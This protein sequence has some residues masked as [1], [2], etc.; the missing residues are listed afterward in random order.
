MNVRIS[1]HA[2]LTASLVASTLASSSRADLT[3]DA[4]KVCADAY[5]QAQTL[6]DA[7][8]L[9]EAR[10]QLRACAQAS[11]SAFIVTDCTEWLADLERLMPSVVLVARD[12]RGSSLS[13]VAVSADGTPLTGALDGGAIE[14][15]PGSHTF[16]FTAADGARA[17]VSYTVLE[18]QKAQAVAVT[19]SALPASAQP[20]LA[21]VEPR[22]LDRSVAS[23][24]S[25]WT[26]QRTLGVVTGGV[27][28]AGVAVGTV[29]GVLML[30]AANGQKTNCSST[31]SCSDY[32][33]ASTDHSTALKDG[34]AATAA[35]IAGGVLIAGGVIL[36]LTAPSDR[37]QVGLTMAPGT[38]TSTQRF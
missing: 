29:F 9:K 13:K 27:G 34:N 16:V 5:T 10:T 38:S 24:P 17:E 36:F 30:S 35:F 31:T 12:A 21:N 20:P 28:V 1:F 23:K 11:C 4:K 2:T 6:R 33:S 22:P 7:H 25:F 8:R 37:A 3:S 18:G 19:L 26:V 14:M 15:D 32:G